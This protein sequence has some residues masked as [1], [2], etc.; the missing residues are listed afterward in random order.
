MLECPHRC[1]HDQFCIKSPNHHCCM[2]TMEIMWDIP[3]TPK[4]LA[5]NLT[6]IM[7]SLSTSL[8]PKSQ[9]VINLDLGWECQ[10]LQ[11]KKIPNQ[12]VG[13]SKNKK[14]NKKK[15]IDQRSEENKRKR[16]VPDQR[17]EENK[18]NIQ[19]SLW[20]RQYLNNT[21]LSQAK[22]RFPLVN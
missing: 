9:L 16:K 7:F 8:E 11:K 22:N 5:K 1:M 6:Y 13:K 21:E 12:R 3:F 15:V 4:L 14:K 18:R 20:T 17:S 2:C 19:R 10:S